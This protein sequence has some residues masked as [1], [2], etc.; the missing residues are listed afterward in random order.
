MFLLLMIVFMVSLTWF[1]EWKKSEV[2]TEY[3]TFFCR[4]RKRRTERRGRRPVE[5][6]TYS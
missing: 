5:Y 6:F 3:K 1:T 2:D 4:R